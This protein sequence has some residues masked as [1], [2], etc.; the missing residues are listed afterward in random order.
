M[1]LLSISI[2][3]VFIRWGILD[4]DSNFLLRGKKESKLFDDKPEKVIEKLAHFANGIIEDNKDI[5]EVSLQFHGVISKEGVI[6]DPPKT[7]SRF[8]KVN[9]VEEFNKVCELPTQ[10]VSSAI[11]QI[12][13]EITY[14]KLKGI[15][16]GVLVN[17]SSTIEGGVVFCGEMIRGH[18]E[19]AGQFGKQLI[20]NKPWESK[21]SSWVLLN[22]I[23][24][25]TG[26][27][28]L[29]TSDLATIVKNNN[30]LFEEYDKWSYRIAEGINNIIVT[31]NPEKIVISGG[32]TNSFDFDIDRIVKH[33]Y[34]FTKDEILERTVIEVSDYKETGCLIGGKIHYYKNSIYK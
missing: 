13:N 12:E 30:D 2:G 15:N 26:N 28:E 7:L 18:S 10:A 20:D 21:A 4:D 17:I 32:I 9:L 23:M 1:S 34:R 16:L 27:T 3:G 24:L 31:I 8:K 5:K 33:L 29:K 22:R 25:M 11:A 19:A 6:V 14:G